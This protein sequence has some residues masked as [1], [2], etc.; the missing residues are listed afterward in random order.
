MIGTNAKLAFSR[1][2]AELNTRYRKKS[3]SNMLF[4]IK[5]QINDKR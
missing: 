4:Q 1:I 5:I 3:R 2:R